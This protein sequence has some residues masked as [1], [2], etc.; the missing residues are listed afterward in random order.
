MKT[1]EPPLPEFPPMVRVRIGYGGTVVIPQQY[2][3]IILQAFNE[4]WTYD[5]D[6]Y[7]G[8]DKPNTDPD[9]Y[10][11]KNVRKMRCG[12]DLF[13]TD[14]LTTALIAQRLEEESK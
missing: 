5:T 6:K 4:G 14:L 3:V 10:H 1:K 7:E 2:A 8:N 11:V 12:V 9:G 13:D